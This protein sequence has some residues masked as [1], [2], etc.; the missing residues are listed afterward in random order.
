MLCWVAVVAL[1]LVKLKGC[2]VTDTFVSNG[3]C[4]HSKSPCLTV[5]EDD[6]EVRCQNS[7]LP[8]VSD[9]QLFC[10]AMWHLS[11]NTYC[12]GDCT[13]HGSTQNTGRTNESRNLLR[14]N[15]SALNLYDVNMILTTLQLPLAFTHIANSLLFLVLSR[16]G[17]CLNLT[18]LIHMQT[19]FVFLIRL[20][21]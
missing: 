8:R 16:H 12:H 13:R 7:F 1:P 19:V 6:L 21:I 17:P 9:R 4:N 5:Q 11:I 20:S 14:G 2:C 10:A 15:W 18:C 3:S